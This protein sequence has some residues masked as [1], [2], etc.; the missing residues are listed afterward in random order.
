[1]D[2]TDFPLPDAYEMCC[3]KRRCPEIRLVP[4]GGA[5]LS[6]PADEA[7]TWNFKE[8]P[9]KERVGI[10]LNKDQATELKKWLES[11]GF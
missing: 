11:K 3:G 8:A 7:E 1:M 4:D 2:D 9:D 5:M 6:V 10:A